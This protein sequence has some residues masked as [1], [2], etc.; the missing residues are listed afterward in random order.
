MLWST[1]PRALTYFARQTGEIQHALPS[2]AFYS[3]PQS[4]VLRFLE[5]GAL[6]PDD[7]AGSFGVHLWAK[8]LRQ[9]LK[10][11]FGGEIPRRSFLELIAREVH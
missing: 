3:V 8:D 9:A 2:N 10:E 7:F 6:K 1:G 5:P 11:N 4:S